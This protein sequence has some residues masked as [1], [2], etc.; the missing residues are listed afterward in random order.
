MGNF[1]K[2][3]WRNVRKNKVYSFINLFGLTAGLVSF[4][5]IALYVFDEFTYDRFHKKAP[6]IYRVVETRTSKEGKVSKVVSCV[7]NWEP[8][9]ITFS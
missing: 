9:V 4:L 1:F 3:F 8:P 6:S 7:A 2:M 5:L